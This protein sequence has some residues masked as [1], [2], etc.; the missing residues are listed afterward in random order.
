MGFLLCIRPTKSSSRMASA[1]CIARFLVSHT[2]FYM[3]FALFTAG[4]LVPQSLALW[5]RIAGTVASLA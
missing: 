5:H 3:V 2:Q 1:S 4:S